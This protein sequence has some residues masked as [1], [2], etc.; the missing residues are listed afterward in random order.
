M[1][2]RFKG[3]KLKLAIQN[4]PAGIWLDCT[5][6]QIEKRRLTRTI[7]P[8]YGAQRTVWKINRHV[9][10]CDDTA[11]GLS[12]MLDSQHGQFWTRAGGTPP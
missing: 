1:L 3:R 4:D 6:N 5:R 9:G 11:K 2:N 10:G 8:D 7:R 12:E